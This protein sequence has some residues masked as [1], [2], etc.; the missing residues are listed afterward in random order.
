MR[1]EYRD[2]GGAVD[3]DVV[4]LRG[5]QLFAFSCST[6][7]KKGLLKTKLFEAYI[8]A[9][10]LGGDEGRIALVCCSNDPDGLEYEMRR[11]VDP[12]GRIRVFGSKHLADLVT[13][14]GQ[15]IR[16]QSKEA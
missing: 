4:A 15:W 11:D 10:Q 5:Y 13:H 16:S 14:V 7:S 2:T 1:P 8:R 3:V 9:R 6:G 12:E